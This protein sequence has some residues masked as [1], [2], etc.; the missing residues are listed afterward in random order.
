MMNKENS[1]KDVL[2]F[3]LFFEVS[4]DL[5]CIAGFDGYF[6]RINPAV[7]KL[8]GY[9]NEELYAKPISEFIY[10]KDR[11]ITGQHRRNL[12]KSTPLINFENRYVTKSGK[13]VWLAWTSIPV[14]KDEIVYAIAKDV[15]HKKKLE[16]ERNLLIENLTTVNN[17]LKLLTYSTSHDL[18]SPVNNLLAV[19]DLLDI[20]KIE[21][22]E[23]LEFIDVL[24]QATESLKDTLNDYVDIL[25]QKNSLK[26]NI[27][28]LSLNDSFN[29]VIQSLNSL[30][31]SSK[32][33]IK[34]DFTE[35]EMV[36]FNKSY[37]ESIFL[38]LITNSIKY[39]R[40][41]YSPVISIYSKR[42]NSISQL[43]YIDEG[44]GF[45]MAK[46]QDKIFGLNQKFNNHKDSKGIG[47]YL[48]YNHIKS[49]GGTITL[50]SKLNEGAKF[51]IVFKEYLDKPVSKIKPIY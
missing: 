7:S 35:V 30:L 29:T 47:L 46:V 25:N 13:I 18:R 2:D 42:V 20:S 16:E 23:T 28:D 4:A 50:E 34:A 45:D 15:T 3:E 11:H 40:P 39:A 19:F 44:Q 14:D 22:E 17:D 51:T 36:K 21:D 37:L 48:V 31:Q 43:I 26:A 38:N 1:L 41:G 12:L 9:S 27:Q 5:L 6:K 24:K 49:L 10:F 32:A 8:L 33:T